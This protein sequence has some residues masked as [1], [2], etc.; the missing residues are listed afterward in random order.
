MVSAAAGFTGG[1]LVPVPQMPAGYVL[2]LSFGI[3]IES[4]SVQIH[5]RFLIETSLIAVFLRWERPIPGS[6]NI[7]QIV[8]E[9][10]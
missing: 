5:E 4:R 8:L 1:F 3:V 10:P 7:N 9:S 2:M 6:W